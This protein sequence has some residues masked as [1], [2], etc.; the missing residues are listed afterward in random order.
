MVL[1]LLVVLSCAYG[2]GASPGSEHSSHPDARMIEFLAGMEYLKHGG[3]GPEFTAV[4]YRALVAAT[5]V[6]AGKAITFLN[7]YRDNPAKLQEIQERVI[8]L[9][10]RPTNK[11]DGEV[12]PVDSASPPAHEKTKKS[13][14]RR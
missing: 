2:L 12:S 9:L 14:S 8:T 13:F 11:A 4:R 10:E 5:G 6:D 1:P 7:S 3:Y